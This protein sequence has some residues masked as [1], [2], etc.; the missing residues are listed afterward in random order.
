M[1]Y[2]KFIFILLFS[3]ILSLSTG[4]YLCL[5]NPEWILNEKTLRFASQFL[6][7]Q[8]W[9]IQWQRLTVQIESESLFKKK[10]HLDIKRPCV[11]SD[12]YEAFGCGSRLYGSTQIDLLHLSF[13]LNQLK[14][15]NLLEF[16]W[17]LVHSEEGTH[18]IIN[19]QTKD[20]DQLGGRIWGRVQ[21]A[22]HFSA[23]FDSQNSLV[24]EGQSDLKINYALKA[25]LT[26]DQIQSQFEVQG[27]ASSDELRGKIKGTGERL[28]PYVPRL[29][30][31][32]C[33]FAYRKERSMDEGSNEI[34]ALRF[35]CDLGIFA[36]LKELQLPVN[37]RSIQSK[38]EADL[39]FSSFIPN[40]E[41]QARGT[42]QISVNPLL[43]SAFQ[44]HSKVQAGI[45]ATL[46]GNF[47]E[48]PPNWIKTSNIEA[49]FSTFR[50]E[51]LVTLLE[52]TSYAVP[53][54]F[55]DLKGKSDLNIQGQW[56]PEQRSEIS[57]SF[58]T[59]LGSATQKFS[60]NG[61]GTL[62]FT[63]TAGRIFPKID[64]KLSL[65]D[66]QMELPPL[67]L[68]N[69][70]RFVSDSR[71][72]P[73]FHGP[74]PNPPLQYTISIQ[75][76]PENPVKLISNLAQAP[77]P[78]ILDLKLSDSTPIQGQIR[79][80]QF[81][82]EVFRRPGT[83][84]YFNLTLADPIEESAIEGTVKLKYVDYK[85]SLFVHSTLGKPQLKV[86]SDPPLSENQTYAVLLFGQPIEELDPEQISTVA[87]TE[88]AVA[89]G[90]VNLAS[91]YL[92]ASTPIQSVGYNPATKEVSVKV[93]LGKGTSLNLG[94]ASEDSMRRI[95]I[96]KRLGPHWSFKTDYKRS[97][98]SDDVVTGYVEWSNRY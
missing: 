15:I 70:P 22:P 75:N 66:V 9:L 71:I 6:A 18:G 13:G 7:T 54:P 39:N 56:N 24:Q 1:K 5:R 34:G 41:T 77:I 87:D 79:V 46:D 20:Q 45:S 85:I 52:N 31:N 27:S 19:I 42:T 28:H 53:A 92:L 8:G 10:I 23:S 95:G 65:S 32:G 4:I 67:A 44:D 49:H 25:A 84:K 3:L 60:T 62:V 55:A 90:A 59:H 57:I 35:Q 98:T 78:I 11:Y 88:A 83:L 76:N 81:P 74:Q 73:Q 47:S 82:I 61:A 63:Q 97:A 21:I 14:D 80:N 68:G 12:I 89:N 36:N 37:L 38:I 50:F 30:V 26:K 91:L 93:R 43:D 29:K 2:I 17:K 16:K 48:L 58:N 86:T 33:D 51:K 64:A 69:P 96:Q 40:P 72:F 94:S